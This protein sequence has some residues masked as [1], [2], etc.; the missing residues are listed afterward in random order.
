MISRF[1][2][3]VL[4]ILAGLG[5]GYWGFGLMLYLIIPGEYKYWFGIEM[6]FGAGMFLMYEVAILKNRINKRFMAWTLFFM[7][8][9]L[10]IG[11]LYL[12]EAWFQPRTA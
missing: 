11:S 8:L 1:E 9:I 10:A 12:I 4:I 2:K 3:V 7:V 5:A 6:G